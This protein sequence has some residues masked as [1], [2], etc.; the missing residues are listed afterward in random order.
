MRVVECNICGE[1]IS[2]ANDEELVGR[3]RDHLESEHDEAPD[4]AESMVSEE[5]YDAMDS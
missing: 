4:S 3:V 2:A 1:A 5:A